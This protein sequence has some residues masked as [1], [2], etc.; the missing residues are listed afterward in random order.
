MSG[1]VSFVLENPIIYKT[2]K[3]IDQSDNSN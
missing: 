2:A 3:H 1:N